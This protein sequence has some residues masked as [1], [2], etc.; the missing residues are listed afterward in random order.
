MVKK[1][2]LGFSIFALILFFNTPLISA[3]DTEN[4]NIP[5]VELADPGMLPDN[6]F[7]FLKIWKEKIQI[8]FTFQAENKAEQY[9]HLAEV[10]LAEY[11][12]MIEK[13]KQQLAERCLERYQNQLNLALEKLDQLE[14]RGKDTELLAQ[15]VSQATLKHIQVLQSVLLKTPEQAEKGLFNALENSQKGYIKAL[16]AIEK[17]TPAGRQE[18]PSQAK[19]E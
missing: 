7:Y 16:E 18:K 4:L 11:Q 2:I 8:F 15:K 17:A 5:Q 14:S 9:L 1:I 19:P 10:R 3:Q 13:G 12:K 6:A